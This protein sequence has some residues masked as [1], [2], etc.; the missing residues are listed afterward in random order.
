MSAANKSVKL[1]ADEAF[2]AG[3][4]LW[5]VEDNDKDKWWNEID[6]R[7]GFLLSAC[8]YHNKKP[9]ASQ[10]NYLITETQLKVYAFAEDQNILLLGSS[11]HFQNK[12]ILLWKNDPAAV[13]EKLARMQSD[14]KIKNVRLFSPNQSLQQQIEA[15]LSASLDQISYV[16]A[17]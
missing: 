16:E 1:D 8:L 3:A 4:E 12:W 6:F 13:V 15:R 14:L 7:S 9:V 2:N 17:L 10:M 5:I 11:D